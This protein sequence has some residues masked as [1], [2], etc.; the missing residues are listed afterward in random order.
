MYHHTVILQ[1][2]IIVW[3]QIKTC[4]CYVSGAG[5]GE[6]GLGDGLE[7]GQVVKKMRD[8]PIEQFTVTCDKHTRTW[9]VDGAGLQRFTQMTNWEWVIHNQQHI[10][11]IFS[12]NFAFVDT[13]NNSKVWI[14][15]IQSFV[16]M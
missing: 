9:Q 6:V 2:A 14:I 8:A 7:V 10:T 16:L 13:Q 3:E 15:Q 12:N 11:D 1:L 5:S 4:G